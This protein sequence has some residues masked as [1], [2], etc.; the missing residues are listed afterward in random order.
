M[1]LAL[2]TPL[3]PLRFYHGERIAELALCLQE[4]T[5]LRVFVRD[6]AHTDPSLRTS[7]RVEP[8]ADLPE[9]V[10]SGEVELPI[11]LLA[12]SAQFAHQ[13]RFVRDVPGLL[14]LLDDDLEQLHVDLVLGTGNG[15]ASERLVRVSRAVLSHSDLNTGCGDAPDPRAL[16]QR[17][18]QRAGELLSQGPSVVA[19]ARPSEPSVEIVI[20]A[21]NSREIIGPCLDSALAQDHP[22]FQVTV[23]DNASADGTAEFVRQRYPRVLLRES[24]ENL[25]F[26]GGNN[27]CFEQSRADY[28]ALLNQ[29][30]LAR[31]DWL[32]E[33]VRVAESD[34]QVAMVGSKMMML[35]CPTI[36][37][38]TGISMNRIGFPVDRQI[39]E[40][41]LDPSPIPEEILGACGGAAL[42]RTEV[43]REIGGFDEL[44]FMYFE[45][46]DLSW[47]IWLSG[48]KILYAPLAVVHH[49]WHGD[50]GGGEQAQEAGAE[51]SE[52][53]E[54]RRRLCERNRLLTMIKNYSLPSL[55]AALIGAKWYDRVRKQQ[56]RD[57]LARGETPNYFRMVERAIRDA[58]SWN[59]GNLAQI[60]RHRRQTQRLRRVRDS[61][62]S[63][64][65]S[66][67]P[68]EPAFIGDLEA[69]ND[70]FSARPDDRVVMGVSDRQALGPGWYGIEPRPDLGVT[71][72][73][74]KA[75]AFA[76]LKPKQDA[77][78][79]TLLAAS[80]PLPIELCVSAGRHV[81]GQRAL[82]GGVLTEI[83]FDLPEPLEAG[84]VHELR[85]DSK[86]FRPCDYG[87]GP[88]TRELGVTVAE[89]R[90]E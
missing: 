2:V 47:R 86:T 39:G 81:V 37:N 85:F 35:R 18:L 63:R 10:R 77:R 62:L 27:R 57:A 21:Y 66:T 84:L 75:R 73:W 20:V 5:D 40:K 7:L 82:E 55:L 46:T 48:R 49:D 78:R 59:L 64:L 72:R 83:S 33:L 79:L 23:L 56:I 26:A 87:M 19:A 6:P 30:A 13:V 45:D 51:Y 89:F 52:K 60:W 70:G 29:D 22:N 65:I 17:L 44:F 34:P 76:Y 8:C 12:D 25:G 24:R 90:L 9:R 61:E 68:G 4:Q 74:S 15:T 3:P 36:L 43:L 1:K 16:A 88:D 11:Y 54:R 80:G 53:T 42:I 71:I 58:W 50:L 69:I 41:D 67:W 31:R 14:V 32:T 38:S 28:V